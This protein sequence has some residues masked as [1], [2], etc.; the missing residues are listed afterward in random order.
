MAFSVLNGTKHV[1]EDCKKRSYADTLGA[2]SD[3]NNFLGRNYMSDQ[4][5]MGYDTRGKLS[6]LEVF[7]QYGM[8]RNEAWNQLFYNEE[9]TDFVDPEDYERYVV[10]PGGYDIETTEGRSAFE[11]HITKLITDFPGQVVP[12]GETF[13]FDTF[14]VKW[15]LIHGK[16]TSRFS[17]EQLDSVYNDVKHLIEN[18]E[19]KKLAQDDADPKVGKSTLGT[20][21]PER[22]TS[23]ARQAFQN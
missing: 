4:T 15:T 21:F 20:E 6:P 1:R 11:S 17:Q 3:W 10:R 23:E 19:Q 16:N 5:P 14:Y 7:I 12:E 2:Q 13:D 22:F 8:F 9:E 18:K